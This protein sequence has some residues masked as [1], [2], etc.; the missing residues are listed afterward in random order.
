MTT[1]Y[2]LNKLLSLAF[3]T[4]L[5]LSI[6]N[7]LIFVTA[8]LG[9]SLAHFWIAAGYEWKYIKKHLVRVRSKIISWLLGSTA[10][11]LAYIDIPLVNGLFFGMHSAL[12]DGITGVKDSTV[13]FPRTVLVWR[14]LF[15]Y[16]L[17]LMM[18]FRSSV[19]L[20]HFTQAIFCVALVLLIYFF[21]LVK[22]RK[23]ISTPLLFEIL[24]L[25]LVTIAM[26]IAQYK[27]LHMHDQ[28]ALVFVVFVHAF[29]WLFDPLFR[30]HFKPSKYDW[31][32]FSLV[33]VFSVLLSAL[34]AWLSTTFVWGYQF[35]RYPFVF[36]FYWHIC[37]HILLMPGKLN[38]TDTKAYKTTA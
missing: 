25:H 1:H 20:T 16:S 15:E 5:Y 11:A 22:N 13:K 35:V 24:G 23:Q 21:V 38:G 2:T 17:I 37:T 29:Y 7:E 10:L 6:K 27:F 31:N 26:V 30:S 36:W 4:F 3:V 18:F 19:V 32:Q 8:I 34:S 9:A 12:S 33:L 14:V 28:T